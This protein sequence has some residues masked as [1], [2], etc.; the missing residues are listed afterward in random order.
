LVFSAFWQLLRLYEQI[1]RVCLDSFCGMMSNF[2]LVLDEKCIRLTS[3]SFDAKFAISI[4]LPHFLRLTNA[5]SG[6]CRPPGAAVGSFT[7]L[8]SKYSTE[9][10]DF[11][12]WFRV[13]ESVADVPKGFA[14]AQI[15]PP[16][17]T[18]ACLTI[19]ARWQVSSMAA[20]VETASPT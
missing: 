2:V 8:I 20:L 4:F 16:P 9:K 12:C 13:C 6:R 19:N 1:D 14:F 5:L 15:V 18:Q 3:D 17:P 11:E 10:M 7:R